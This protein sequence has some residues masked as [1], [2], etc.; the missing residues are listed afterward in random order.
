MLDGFPKKLT[1]DGAASPL[2]VDLDGDNRNELVLG[3]SDGFVHA[4]ER[5]GSEVDGWP[6]R[7]DP[8]PLHLGGRAFASGAV[9]DNLGGAVLPSP[10]AADIDH[11]GSPEVVAADMNGRLYVWNAKGE[12][13]LKR[14]SNIAWSGKPLSPFDDVRYDAAANENHRRRTQHGFLASPVLADIDQNDH[15]RLEI[16]I[17]GMDRHVYAWNDD[18]T[19]V[20]G[21][22]VLVVDPG[23]VAAIN[24]TTHAVDF[25]ET[26]TGDQLNQGSIV[27]TPAIGNLDGDP[28][29][30]PEIVVGTNE[31]YAAN[32]GDEGPGNYQPSSFS[33]ASAVLSPG[34]SRLYAIKPGGDPDGVG[35]ASP[36][37]N[38]W[39]VKVAILGTETLPVVGEGMTGAPVLSEFACPSGGAGPKVGAISAV[40]PAYVFNADGTGCYGKA[41]GTDITLQSD[42]ALSP[43]TSDRPAIPAFG[44]PLFAPGFG[45]AGMT[46]AA[47]ATGLKRALDVGL[48]EYQMEG[49][50]MVAAWVAESPGGVMRP[51][52]PA[53]VNDLQFLSGPAVADID[54]APGGGEEMIA[55]SA[56]NDLAAYTAAGAAPVGGKWPKTTSDWMVTTPLT[57]SFGTLD[58]DDSAKKTV[59]AITR[60]GTLFAYDTPAGACAPGSWPKFHHDNANSGDS[61]RD[62]TSPGKPF[63]ATYADGRLTFRAP[64][65]D[66]LCGTA[67]SYEVVA[68]DSAITGASFSGGDPVSGAPAP[69]A[70]GDHQVFDV[71]AGKRFVALRAVDEQ[72]NVGRPVV[73][74]RTAPNGGLG[75]AGAPSGPSEPGAGGPGT[76]GPGTGGPGAGGPGAG[77]TKLRCLPRTWRLH[78]TGFGRIKVGASRTAA[79][80]AG[81]TPRTTTKRSLTWCVTGGGRVSAALS[82]T[83]RVQL[84]GTTAKGKAPGRVGVRSSLRRVTRVYGKLRRLGKALYT[85]S[86]RGP[87]VFGVRR[88]KVRYAAI[89]DR[90][91]MSRG[92]RG[93]LGLSLGTAGFR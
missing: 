15:G 58:V 62:A 17:P 92:R 91:L 34:N 68:S 39:P 20:D 11:D 14:E 25:D 19:P 31:E 35:G 55:G 66:L 5:D 30:P 42:A 52:F 84:V 45:G 76:G 50:D 24:P 64:G 16:V 12:R 37:V 46:F 73:V 26:K 78:K 80:R 79:I 49:Q 72:G 6:V 8:P 56:H 90:R 75:D 41:G 74:D 27:D 28:D 54:G 47:P 60:A 9:P 63:E 59:V 38:G 29:S 70:A 65:D 36:F 51:G 87:F 82:S 53:R 83:G 13:I 40:G 67:K 4:Y 86:R 77:G 2:F 32:S 48:N 89:A 21:F 61:R 22:P 44:Q 1:S 71:P 33:A 23:K 88:G 57:G 43:T 81:G 85:G 69:A 10:A 18:G 7:S 3:S 93:Q